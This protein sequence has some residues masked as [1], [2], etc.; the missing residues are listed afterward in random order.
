MI[1]AD[2]ID[3]L[4]FSIQEGF[5]GDGGRRFVER[6]SRG[7]LTRVVAPLAL[8]VALAVAVLFMTLAWG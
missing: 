7:E 2:L 5:G 1:I 3:A 6:S 4:T 8:S